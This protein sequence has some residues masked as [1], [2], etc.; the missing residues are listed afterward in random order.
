MNEGVPD[1]LASPNSYPYGSWGA[2][3]HGLQGSVPPM[4]PSGPSPFI[5]MPLDIESPPQDWTLDALAGLTT[6]PQ[7]PSDSS[8]S[9]S[10]SLPPSNYD[11][12]LLTPQTMRKLYVL[13]INQY[14]ATN[15]VTN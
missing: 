1:P 9:S 14:H 8:L 7:P 4:S 5:S 15:L 2:N 6:V 3:G 11:D 12:L 13:Y 10:F